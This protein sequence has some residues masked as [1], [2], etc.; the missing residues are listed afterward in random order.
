MQISP[1]LR[2]I[3][4]VGLLGLALGACSG[5]ARQDAGLQLASSLP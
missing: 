3:A 1:W 5:G 4:V 2:R